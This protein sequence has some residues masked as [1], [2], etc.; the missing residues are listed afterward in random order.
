MRGIRSR[1][2][3]AYL[4]IIGL[5]LSFAGILILQFLEQAHMEQVRQTLQEEGKLAAAWLTADGRLAGGWTD[6]ESGQAVRV[7]RSLG[8]ELSLFDTQ[9]RLLYDS[10]GERGDRASGPEVV[11]A[12]QGRVGSEIR[13][14]ERLHA[15]VYYVAVPVTEGGKIRGVVRVGA[16]FAPILAGLQ[17]L[18]GKVGL[19]LLISGLLAALL[20]LYFS[21]KLAQPIQEINRVVRRI[22]EGDVNERV[23]FRNSDELGALSESINGMAEKIAEQIEALTQEKSKLEGILAHMDSGVIVVDRSG[24][25]QLVNSAFG[26]IFGVEEERF[27]GRWH[28]ECLR[29]YGLSSLIDEVILHGEIKRQE[30]NVY[31]PEE[32]TVE[33]IV[34]PIQ[35]KTET[36]MGA[37]TVLHDISQWRRLERM[38][39]EFVANVSHELR[40]PITAVKGF[41]ETL[42]DGAL[43][44]PDTA[45]QFVHIIYEESERLSRLVADLLD[46]SQ[47]EHNR[48]IWR[49]ETLD[50][51][52]L[53]RSSIE[54]LRHQAEQNGLSLIE[55]WPEKPVRVEADRD[56]IAQ[57]MINLIAN[58]ITYTPRGGKID[59][60]LEEEPDRVTVHVR[61]TG[62]GIPPQD[63]SRLFER[64][65]R[66][67]KARHRRSGGTG[68]GLA[69]VKHIL[70]AHHGTIHVQ[71]EV[72]KGSDF[73]FTL[74]KRQPTQETDA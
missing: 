43:A 52:P 16:P 61:D 6:E 22:A 48:S 14:N 71:S 34:T 45:R 54:K 25:I 63:L 56:R 5:A 67:D 20:S 47:I 44:D 29:S 58:A 19:S 51:V 37:V 70:E 73:A 66:V 10:E 42:L 41:A 40:T 57:V 24:T 53:L 3:Y 13:E 46:L 62:I 59:V 8:K 31:T 64:F 23:R 26:T 74:P 69:I 39:S 33:V 60:W 65:Y 27:L 35:G 12:L 68:L 28:W 32:R 36:V 55:Q 11:A 38:R 7:A 17:N 2:M 1:M 15:N 30:M 49:F 18:W 21:H 9:G 4:L 72:G 50:L